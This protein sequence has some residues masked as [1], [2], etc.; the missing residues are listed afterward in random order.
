[1][2]TAIGRYCIADCKIA[3]HILEKIKSVQRTLQMAFIANIPLR[4]VIQKAQGIK[5]QSCVYA[6][7]KQLGFVFTQSTK[8]K[9][10]VEGACVLTPK[11]GFFVDPQIVLDFSSLYPS[12]IISQNYSP[13]LQIS[14]SDPFFSEE[15]VNHVR[16]ER[17]NKTFHSLNL[18]EDFVD[19]YDF[20]KK[21]ENGQFEGIFPMIL[22]KLLD[23]R[24][25]VRQLMKNKDG[26]LT[27][28][29]IMILDAQQLSIKVLCNSFYG[30]LGARGVLY[31][32]EIARCTTKT[33][34]DALKQAHD[35]IE[36]TLNSFFR[37]LAKIEEYCAKF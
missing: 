23:E 26:K 1:M 35:F 33:G 12:T 9:I 18:L 4:Y 30:I 28:Q 25:K 17:N 27:Q 7:C 5:V 32:P 29:Q 11:L 31:C 19:N 13:E 8:Q 3:F 2:R 21:Q 22:R 24:A 15:K 10:V 34:R 37:D 6:M 20:V 16:I 36:I 14:P